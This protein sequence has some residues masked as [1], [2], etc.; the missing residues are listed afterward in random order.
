MVRPVKGVRGPAPVIKTAFLPETVVLTLLAF[1]SL[2][3]KVIILYL[4]LLSDK[5]F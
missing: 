5:I 1:A 4:L 3:F 2:H